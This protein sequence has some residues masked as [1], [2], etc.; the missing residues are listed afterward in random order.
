MVAGT[1]RKVLRPIA[2]GQSA[3]YSPT[4][5]EGPA[6]SQILIE[7][8]DFVVL[9]GVTASRKAFR[10]HLAFS[11][12][13]ETARAVRLRRG[14]ERDGEQALADWGRWMADEDAYV[15]REQPAAYVDVALRGDEGPWS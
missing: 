1:N 4:G 5:W 11:I 6:K 10:S 8:A 13:I 7:P 12:W 9:E 2:V 15:E 14:L 3:R